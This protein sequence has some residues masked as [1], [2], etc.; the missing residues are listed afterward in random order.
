MHDVLETNVC[1]RAAVLGSDFLSSYFF[2]YYFLV[3]LDWKRKKNLNEVDKSFGWG[4]N[5]RIP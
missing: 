3:H 1:Q 2:F 5:R 4:E